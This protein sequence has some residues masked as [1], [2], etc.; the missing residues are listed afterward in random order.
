M[1]FFG[2]SE[3]EDKRRQENGQTRISQNCH[4]WKYINKIITFIFWCMMSWSTFSL[5]QVRGL[6]AL[7]ID[8]KVWSGT[9]KIGPWSLTMEIEP[10]SRTM[11]KAIFHG[12]TSWSMVWTALSHRGG[13]GSNLAVRMFST[14]VPD[15]LHHGGYSF[16]GRVGP[17]MPHGCGRSIPLQL[18]NYRCCYQQY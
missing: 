6:K 18:I 3:D 11:E 15:N 7:Q 9:M 10:W 13:H 17:Y 14:V 4:F 16:W 12:P 1:N 8:F 5:H 2:G